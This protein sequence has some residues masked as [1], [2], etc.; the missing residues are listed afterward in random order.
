MY[1]KIENDPNFIYFK[2]IIKLE[3][4]QEKNMDLYLLHN[5][6]NISITSS[7]GIKS[8]KFLNKKTLKK[9][10]RE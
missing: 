7:Q 4:W 5:I 2:Q 8:E 1:M 9:M 6:I 10:K 3:A